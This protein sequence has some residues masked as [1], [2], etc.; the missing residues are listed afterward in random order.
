MKFILLLVLLSISRILLHYSEVFSMVLVIWCDMMKHLKEITQKKLRLITKVIGLFSRKSW[1]WTSH[2][3]WCM[4]EFAGSIL[5]F[6][7]L[8]LFAYFWYILHFRIMANSPHF[9]NLFLLQHSKCIYYLTQTGM[10]MCI[11]VFSRDLYNC[12]SFGKAISGPILLTVEPQRETP[13]QRVERSWEFW[14]LI[15]PQGTSIS[16][17]TCYIIPHSTYSFPLERTDPSPVKNHTH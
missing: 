12:E 10:K 7:D 3:K 5:Y 1:A 9:L 14:G 2:R 11:F 15:F 13:W 17:L 8:F 16:K 4:W 6:L